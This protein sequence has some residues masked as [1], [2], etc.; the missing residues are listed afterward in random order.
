MSQYYPI[1]EVR[2]CLQSMLSLLVHH[3]VVLW[4]VSSILALKDLTYREA[5]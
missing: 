3:E 5:L 1:F 2:Y 4:V